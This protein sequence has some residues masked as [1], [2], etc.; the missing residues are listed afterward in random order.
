[1]STINNFS[2]NTPY[3]GTPVIKP[4]SIACGEG[5]NTLAY[6][7]DGI[8]WKGLGNNTFSTRANKAIW[9]GVMWVAVGTGRYWVASSYDGINWM[10]RDASLMTEAY[11]IAWNGTVFVA[12]GYGGLVNLA[13]S[14]DGINWYGL[15]YSA[16]LFSIR[17]SGV[18]WTGRLWLVYGSGGN[19]TGY[20]TD[21]DAWFWQPTSPSNLVITDASSAITSY[22]GI[23]Y[24]SSNFS[25]S[26]LPA[27]AIDNSMNPTN[28]TEWR[29]ISSSYSSTT[30]TNLGFSVST[31]YNTNLT[32]SGEWIQINVNTSCII[33]YYHISCYCDV[34]GSNY[35]CPKEWYLLGSND[36]SD[37]KL[38]DYFNYGVSTPPINTTQYP[39]FIK[40]RNIY[41]NNSAYQCYRFVIPSIFPGGSLSYVRVSELDLFC[42]NSNSDTISPFIKPIITK[43][44]VLYQTNIIPF[45]NSTKKQT[46]YQIADLCGNL[47]DNLTVNINNYTNNIIYGALNNNI[48]SST[49]DGDNLIVTPI[50]GNICYINNQN[51]NTKLNFDISLNGNVILSGISTVYAS[52]FNGQRILLGGTGGNVITYNA[53]L[54]NNINKTFTSTLNANR[55]FSTVYGLASNSGYGFVY[56]P[57]RI[58]FSPGDKLTVVAPKSY[59]KNI[60]NNNTI[61][62]NL[63]NVNIIKNI[64]L[65]TPVVIYGL[66]GTTGTV[67]PTGPGFLGNTGFTGVTGPIGITGN[68]P[69]G[70]TGDAFIGRTGPTGSFGPTGITGYNGN[71]GNYGDAGYL[72]FNGTTGTTGT[73]GPA[74]PIDQSL[75]KFNGSSIYTTG[76][77]GLGTNNPNYT[78]DVSG[79][80]NVNGSIIVPQPN[81]SS[82]ISAN[83]IIIGNT[84]L[85]PNTN[86]AMDVKGNAKIDGYLL[87]NKTPNSTSLPSQNNYVIDVSGNMRVS[88]I[89]AKNTYQYFFLPKTILP[90][91]ITLDYNTGGNFYFSIDNT[92]LTN[93]TTEILNF[94][95]SQLPFS[96]IFVN[97]LIDYSQMP[98][99]YFYCDRL[100]IFGSE[101]VPNFNGGNP[102]QLYSNFSTTHMYIQQ[103]TI[104]CVNGTIWKVFCDG[105]AYNN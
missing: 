1:M 14:R 23:A 73:T 26:Y 51:L 44:N 74:G 11:D 52:C 3:I 5:T 17:A 8:Y 63:N 21:A 4:L 20:S 80:I 13:A 57:N 68:S 86:T 98:N 81:I 22:S 2:W 70:F 77:V 78:L 41:S 94:P 58:Y 82:N 105:T 27:N 89:Q 84:F 55:L 40:L 93:F 6:S 38:L 53:S 67:G 76:N 88:S 66:V 100:L 48:T 12:T 69:T 7:E 62:M 24:S 54:T 65:P 87:I 39:F 102:K 99:E 75:W 10:G 9:N 104:V 46:V 36:G 32:A 95:I 50:S 59:N 56:S 31:N 103:F 101:Y 30:G 34:S 28:S 45:S 42:T 96:S 29:S 71:T 61:S 35:T 18:A 64:T 79:N 91:I 15:P 16:S 60:F 49:F 90:H 33:K 47:I 97:L 83:H 25:S 85:H 92:I 43:T 72:G 19:T 37:W